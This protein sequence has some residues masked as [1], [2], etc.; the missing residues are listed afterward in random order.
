MLYTARHMGMGGTAIGY[1]SDPSAMFHNP[2]GLGHIENGEVIGDFSLLLGGIHASP[3]T[4]TGKDV[5]SDL[6]VAP[7]FLAGAGYRI[8]KNGSC[9]AS[10]SIRSPRPA[11]RTTTARPASRITPSCSSSRRRPRS[12]STRCPTCDLASAIV[13]PTC[14]SFATKARRRARSDPPVIDFRMTGQNFT[15]FRGGVQWDALPW[16]HFGGVYRN[17][18]TTRVSNSSGYALTNSYHGHLDSL[19]AAGEARLRHAR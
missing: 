1:V 14:A 2:A 12:R 11:R 19:H 8:Q 6:T 16:L 3:N 10:A 9:L 15:G 4:G 5:D 13:L 17:K 18:V 7:F